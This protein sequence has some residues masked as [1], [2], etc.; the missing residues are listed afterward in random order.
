MQRTHFAS[1]SNKLFTSKKIKLERWDLRDIPNRTA[2]P[3]VSHMHCST[4]CEV[5]NSEAREWA[6]SESKYY[7]RLIIYTCR[8]AF[9][10]TYIETEWDALIR[11]ESRRRVQN[12]MMKTKKWWNN[13]K[14]VCTAKMRAQPPKLHHTH[15]HTQRTADSVQHKMKN[16]MLHCSWQV[17]AY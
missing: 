2:P 13:K 3:L 14:E 17:F 7:I 12:E 5:N 11:T 15:T 8:H 9:V 1:Q 6:V 10:M 16:S 4:Q